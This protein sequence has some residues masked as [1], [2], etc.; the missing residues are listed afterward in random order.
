MEQ[1]EKVGDG[2]VVIVG[3][4]FVTL[5]DMMPQFVIHSTFPR[6]SF[7]AGILDCMIIGIGKQSINL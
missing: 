6:G 3:W 2:L 1:F 7:G 5:V 4:L